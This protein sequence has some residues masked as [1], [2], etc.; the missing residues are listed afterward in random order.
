MALKKLLKKYQLLTNFNG[1]YKM[2]NTT[3]DELDKLFIA[4]KKAFALELYPSLE[5]RLD[6]LR[7]LE[8]VMVKN[9]VALQESVKADF[10][11]HHALVTDLFETGAVAGRSRNIQANLAEWMKPSERP[12]VSAV[13]GSSTAKVVRSPKGVIGVIGPWNFPIECA[14]IMTN[15]IMAGGNR[16]IVKTASNTPAT[17]EV[18]SEAIAKVFDPTELAIVHGPEIRGYFP[19]LPWNHLTYTGGG[20]VGKK[21]MAAAAANLTP[22][23]LELGGKNPTL[24]TDTGITEN[25]IERWLF[26]RVFKG[27]QVCT[28][29]DYALVPEHCIDQWV[30]LA[31][32]CWSKMYKK[33]VGHPD[34]TSTI[35]QKHFERI[36]GYVEE[37]RKGGIEVISLNGDAPDVATRQ[38]PMYVIVNPSENMAVMKE[39]IF[40]PVSAV[41]PYKT[42]EEAIKYISSRP[43]PLAAYIAGREPE[44]IEQFTMNV[45]AGG[46]GI[47]TF[48]FQAADPSLPFGGIGESGMGCHSGFEGFLNYTHQKSVFNCTDDN[49]LMQA[50]KLPFG[51]FSQQMADMIFS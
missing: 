38:I 31:K 13:H 36:L 27:G 11:S 18:L 22:V 51:D 33:Y 32:S 20:E 15:E 48:G 47:N 19:T 30:S 8:S 24:F 4:Q 1:G 17:A 44:L 16:A 42:F 39:E 40:G 2:K 3:K 35:T 41:I 14:L 45:I 7:R 23:T 34:A 25:L 29:P 6:R 9:R 21:I 10:G 46:I 28:S 50:I 43:R 37:A 12:L 26:Y 49:V 5:M